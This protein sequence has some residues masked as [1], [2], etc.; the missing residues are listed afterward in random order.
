MKFSARFGGAALFAAATLV[1]ALLVHFCIVLVI[2]TVAARDA[3]ARL[4]ELGP[5][6]VT[7]LLPRAAPGER[8]FPWDDPAL[9][10]A[11]CRFDL[12]NGPVRV[13]APTGRAGFASLSFHTRHGAVFYALT[14]RAATRGRMEAVIVSPAQLRV[15][16]AH[17]DEDDPSQDLRVVSP[18]SEGFVVMRAFSELPSL[19]TAASD[20]TQAMTC[21]TEL[22]PR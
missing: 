21:V 1:I 9:A 20:E 4:A 22:L 13:K 16:A 14:D 10:G 3:F 6:G 15:L 19:Y 17:D 8:R 2:P 5:P 18:T 11:F 7:T 12:A